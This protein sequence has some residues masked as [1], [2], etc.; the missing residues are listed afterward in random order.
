[1]A[2]KRFEGNSSARSFK[3]YRGDDDCAEGE[4]CGGRHTSRF[5]EAWQGDVD[6]SDERCDGSARVFKGRR[7]DDDRA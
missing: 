3:T 2:S 4:R 7:R 5:S 1:M 6:C